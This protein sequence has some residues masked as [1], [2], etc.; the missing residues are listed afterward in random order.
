[1]KSLR[2]Q[3]EFERREEDIL[4]AALTLFSGPGWESVS[5]DQ[6]A[7][8]AEIGK[9]TVYNHFGSKDELLFRLM[10]RFYEGLLVQVKQETFDPNQTL[11]SFERIFRLAFKYHLDHREY[12]YVVEYCKRIDFRERAEEAWRSSFLDLDRAF[13]EWGDPMLISAMEQGL[14][15]NRPTGHIHMGMHACFNGAIEMLWAGSDWCLH[16]DETEILEAVTAF[17]MA[18]VIGQR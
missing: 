16:G 15:A 12:R 3:R 17:M 11:T 7:R 8:L 9:G 14:I 2:K 13:S 4:D 18:G 1:M 10:L 6:I 5:I